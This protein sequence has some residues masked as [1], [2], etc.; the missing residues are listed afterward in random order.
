[1]V[2]NGYC[3]IEIYYLNDKTKY[4]LINS[5][6]FVENEADHKNKYLYLLAQSTEVRGQDSLEH[7][8]RRIYQ[9]DGVLGNSTKLNL[10]LNKSR[11]KRTVL[12]IKPKKIISLKIII[13]KINAFLSLNTAY[14]L[15]RLHRYS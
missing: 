9:Y 15:S 8:S 4:F 10:R 1:M 12:L 13:S 11:K 14:D 6:F 2:K 7:H 3:K 5:F